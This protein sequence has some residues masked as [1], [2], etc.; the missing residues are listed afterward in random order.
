MEMKS[1]CFISLQT[2]FSPDF[3][4]YFDNKVMSQEIIA[5]LT[6]AETVCAEAAEK[7]VVFYCC[8]LNFQWA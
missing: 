6:T 2:I 5:N 1:A 4:G 3:S 8:P 7:V